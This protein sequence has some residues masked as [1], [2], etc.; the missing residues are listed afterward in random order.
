MAHRLNSHSTQ[1]SA[2]CTTWCGLPL[3]SSHGS[4]TRGVTKC[5]GDNHKK[6]CVVTICCNHC[7]ANRSTL[8]KDNNNREKRSKRE[9]VYNSEEI[10]NWI[11]WKWKEWN[12]PKKKLRLV[13]EITDQNNN[14][15]GSIVNKG[16]KGCE[17]YFVNDC[18]TLHT[19]H[20]N[21]CICNGEI[22]S[23]QKLILITN[24]KLTCNFNYLMPTSQPNSLSINLYQ[25][26]HAL[27]YIF[28]MDMYGCNCDDENG[29]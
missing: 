13:K 14:E 24:N 27:E 22:V 10:F 4:N 16:N 21:D 15:N 20:N 17:L 6:D 18:A 11:E 1:L 8:S 19:L 25:C 28:V 7:S 3:A 29:R 5:V 9:I 23:M 12:G 2:T 26:N